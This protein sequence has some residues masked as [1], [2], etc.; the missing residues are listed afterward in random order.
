MRKQI[1]NKMSVCLCVHTREGFLEEE[2]PICMGSGDC[3][4]E[5][6]LAECR[7]WR[8]WDYSEASVG[9]PL[10]C[11]FL[12]LSSSPPVLYST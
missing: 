5:R 1:V 3:I 2:D 10:C 6:V 11:L 9:M 7:L 8:H 12:T 4:A